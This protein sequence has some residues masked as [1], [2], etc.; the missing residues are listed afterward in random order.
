MG[1]LLLV[2]VVVAIP[3]LFFGP[4][5]PVFENR[6]GGKGSTEPKWMGRGARPVIPTQSVGM[7][8]IFL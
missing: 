5:S 1:T 8:G 4:E 7:T 2:I 6:T 3:S